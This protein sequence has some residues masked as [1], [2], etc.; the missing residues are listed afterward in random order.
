[1]HLFVCTALVFGSA[2][3]ISAADQTRQYILMRCFMENIPAN[4]T[5]DTI[6]ENWYNGCKWEE[7]PQRFEVRLH[8]GFVDIISI[9]GVQIG[10]FNYQCAPHS[11][12]TLKITECKQ[13]YEFDTRLL[14]RAG[15]YISFYQNSLFGSLRLKE[16]PQLIKEFSVAENRLKGPIDLTELPKIIRRLSI[17][18]N[19]I[20]QPVVFYKDLPEGMWVY[21]ADNRIGAVEPVNPEDA[22]DQNKVFKDIGKREHPVALEI[23]E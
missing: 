5:D 14:P 18:Q 10:N 21:L 20:K 8:H 22:V 12:R 17:R 2:D 4:F 13:R 6:G 1:M 3:E 16:L 19:A 15:E 9:R 23:A 11:A 7:S